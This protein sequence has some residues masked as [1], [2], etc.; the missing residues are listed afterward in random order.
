MSPIDPDEQD[1]PRA[2]LS[3]KLSA[4]Q[5]AD[6][7]LG[8]DDSGDQNVSALSEGL[9]RYRS[10]DGVLRIADLSDDAT[11]ELTALCDS[12]A[13]AHGYAWGEEEYP[14]AYA[15]L[16]RDSINDVY[17][18]DYQDG[19]I[20]DDDVKRALNKA[21]R[22]LRL[23]AVE[24]FTGEELDI[25]RHMMPAHEVHQSGCV[26]WLLEMGYGHDDE[27]VKLRTQWREEI[28]IEARKRLEARKHG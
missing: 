28:E 14:T 27:T 9:S 17:G 16:W 8:D 24:T 3:D 1:D 2:E 4:I 25:V 15:D 11:T 21:A 20:S 5:T 7:W 23:G 6:W 26:R 12:L 10:A 22:C 18:Y 13:K 19:F